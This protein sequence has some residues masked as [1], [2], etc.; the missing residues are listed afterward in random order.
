MQRQWFH[1]S[2]RASPAYIWCMSCNTATE[3]HFMHI[4]DKHA[5]YGCLNT[6]TG[7][8]MWG[9]YLCLGIGND[10]NHY[11]TINKENMNCVRHWHI[12]Q[13][14][15]LNHKS[16]LC[17]GSLWSTMSKVTIPSISRCSCQCV[18]PAWVLWSYVSIFYHQNCRYCWCFH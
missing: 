11:L 6:D 7:I 1:L 2:I 18:Y 14:A 13:C 10:R 16:F 3:T 4:N 15:T 8:H 17:I 5:Q 9:M 12:S